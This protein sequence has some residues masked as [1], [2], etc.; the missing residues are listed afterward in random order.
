LHLQEVSVKTFRIVLLVMLATAVA[1]FSFS[2][3]RSDDSRGRRIVLPA[4]EVHE[5]WYFAGAG[6]VSI[7]GTING[8]AYIAGGVVEVDGT[9]NGQLI[10]AGGQVTVSGNVTDRIFAGGGSIRIAGKTGKSVVAAGGTVVIGKDAV[11]GE[12]L[13]AAGGNIQVYGT[14]DRE[15]RVAGGEIELTGV[16]KGNLDVTA[17]RFGTYQ[18]ALVGGN[19][20]VSTK[21][22]S[23]ISVEPGTVAGSVRID[24]NHGQQS[25]HILWLEKGSFWFQVFFGLTL[26]ATALALAFLLPGHLTSPAGILLEHPGQSLLWGFILLIVTPVVSLILC[27][28][29]IGIPLGLFLFVLY[30]WLLYAS[31]LVVGIAVGDRL[32][33]LDGKKGWALFGTVALGLLIVQVFMFVPVVRILLIV[34]GLLFGVGSLAIAANSALTALR[35]R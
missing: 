8:D 23:R 29:V 10:V 33:G 19:L 12:N 21:D 15:A 31:Q 16:V 13:L 32:L 20:S 27:I 4:G 17:D 3:K 1:G 34:V 5:G 18:G 30:L 22:S 6:Q 9:I 28:T 2:D 35:A 26:F 24:V 11:V 7:Q 25:A 14:V